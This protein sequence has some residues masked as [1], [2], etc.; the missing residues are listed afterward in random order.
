MTVTAAIAV[1]GLGV[2]LL[3]TVEAP[4]TEAVLRVL[5]FKPRAS[6]EPCY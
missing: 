2:V 1:A 5:D 4:A 6:Y 3:A